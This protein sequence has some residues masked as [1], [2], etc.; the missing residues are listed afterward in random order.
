MHY[1]SLCASA[2][3]FTA[4][5]ILSGCSAK[6]D[7]P[8]PA[9]QGRTARDTALGGPVTVSTLRVQK[10]DLPVI[11]KANGTVTPLNSV[12]IKAQV[13]NVIEKVHVREGQSVLRGQ[14]LFTLDARSDEVNTAAK[15]RAQLAKDT[16][17]LAD[18][19]RQLA[20]AQQLFNQNFISRGGVDT[21]QALVESLAFVSLSLVPM[22]ASRWLHGAT[23][24]EPSGYLV[25][26]FEKGFNHLLAGYTRVLDLALRYRKSV[27][28]V[29]AATFL[30]TA[31][32]FYSI[33]KGFFPEED[34]GQIQMTT[35]ASEDTSFTDMVRLQ[36]LAAN[37]N[38]S[39]LPCTQSV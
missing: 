2:F 24:A 9:P 20:R 33:P 32:L 28:L 16:A 30:A 7:P 36:E 31:W 3:C 19:E 15:A 5:A 6:E 8:T 38:A 10:R 12:D 35:E 34:I 25:R 4:C 22:L 27:L 18:A 39:N 11:L 13:N 26:Q 1:F 21:A 23:H 29:A 17:A 37:D 14:L